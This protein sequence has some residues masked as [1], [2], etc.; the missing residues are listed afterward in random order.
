MKRERF[1][2]GIP[3]AGSLIVIFTGL[4]L[5]VFAVL[6]ISGAL[7]GGRLSE[8]SALN[9]DEYYEADLKAE[10]ILAGIRNGEMP[11]G[12]TRSGNMYSY[13]VDI[14]DSRQLFVEAEV[15]DGDYRIIKWQS[16]YTGEWSDNSGLEVW[17]GTD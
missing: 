10:T 8:A 4:C 7:A 3:G 14:N 5:V 12:V 11:D 6:A 17:T 9:N 2:M 13:C 1:S 15:A 16:A